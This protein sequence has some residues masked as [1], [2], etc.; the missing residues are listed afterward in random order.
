[1]NIKKII[2]GLTLSLLLSSGMVVA[3]DFDKGLDAYYREDGQAAF[4]EWIPLA[5]QGNADAQAMLG[6][7]YSRTFPRW[8][9]SYKTSFG[10][11]SKAAEQGNAKA[12][13][14]LGSM[15]SSGRGIPKDDQKSLEW[16]IKSAHQ[17]DFEAQQ[18]LGNLYLKGQV[19]PKDNLRAYM[20]FNLG[21]FNAD[22]N[23]M[24]GTTE[25]AREEI[26]KEMTPADVSKAQ[27]MS[28]RCLE[29]NYTD[30]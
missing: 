12:Q 5:E 10:W 30:C 13:R 17:G 9:S 19:I 2:A 3:A 23:F 1:M 8:I 26:A 27:E 20:W 25:D 28:S 7:L 21:V 29:S 24:V 18:E 11:Y 4:V 22:M 14:E 15:Y 16:Y 6:D